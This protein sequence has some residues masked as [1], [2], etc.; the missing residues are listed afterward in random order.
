MIKDRVLLW[1]DMRDM[2]QLFLKRPKY[3]Y[4]LYKY[5]YIFDYD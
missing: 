5:I 2:R 1:R 3:E 4:I